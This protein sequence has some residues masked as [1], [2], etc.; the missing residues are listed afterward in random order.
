[1][2]TAYHKFHI[3]FPKEQN[4]SV[5]YDLQIFIKRLGALLLN[6]IISPK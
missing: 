1:M 4:T 5:F 2:K 3:V 6:Y